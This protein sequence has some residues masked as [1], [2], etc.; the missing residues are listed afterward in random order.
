MGAEYTRPPADYQ[1]RLPAAAE[2]G[3][4]RR[5]SRTPPRGP[6]AFRVARSEDGASLQEFLAAKLGVSRRAAKQQIDARVVRVDGQSVWMAHHRLRAG[7]VVTVAG[8]VDSPTAVSKRPDRAEILFEDADFLVAD[9]PRGILVNE[10]AF[11]L[12][13]LLRQQTGNPELRASHR[14]DRDTTGCVLFSKSAA[15]HAAV[16][17]VFK[18]HRVAKTYRTVV[19]GR[20]DAASSTIDLPLDGRRALSQIHCLRANAK[21]S[22]LAVRIETGRTHQIRRHLAMARHPVLGD[23]TYGPKVVEDL[24]LMKLTY[25]LLHAVE[26]EMDHPTRP[27]ELLRVFSPL[28]AQALWTA[29]CWMRSAACRGSRCQF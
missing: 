29:G 4:L 22:H 1:A 7:A 18:E 28:P 12:E 16:V 10:A 6:V 2:S 13:T 14:L 17:A 23:A 24:R 19:H 21:A 9:K 15:A 5:M 26:L 3:I 11:S 27:G 20:W 8:V 25:P